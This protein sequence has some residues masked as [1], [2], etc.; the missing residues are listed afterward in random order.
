MNLCDLHDEVLGE[1]LQLLTTKDRFAGVGLVNR[2]LH[3]L[4]LTSPLPTVSLFRIGPFT[5]SPFVK[6]F[7]EYLK[8]LEDE[9]T[10]S[11]AGQRPRDVLSS[12]P[13]S[14]LNLVSTKTLQLPYISLYALKELAN[15]FPNISSCGVAIMKKEEN[16]SDDLEAASLDC[17]LRFPRLQSLELEFNRVMFPLQIPLTLK[18]FKLECWGDHMLTPAQER[19]SPFFRKLHAELPKAPLLEDYS[20][21]SDLTP[22]VFPNLKTLTKQFLRISDIPL[23]NVVELPSIESLSL[24]ADFDIDLSA[25]N[26]NRFAKTLKSLQLINGHS[27]QASHV[28]E[29]KLLDLKLALLTDLEYFSM[30][31]LLSLTSLTANRAYNN[32]RRSK[33]V[34]R[35]MAMVSQL[36]NL[37][38]LSL[39]GNFGALDYST[40]L[41]DILPNLTQFKFSDLPDFREDVDVKLSERFDR[42]R[43]IVKALDPSKLRILRLEY[44]FVDID[45]AAA[46]TEFT[47][48]RH[49]HL[50]VMQPLTVQ[51]MEPFKLMTYLKTLHLW[52]STRELQID[53]DARDAFFRALPNTAVFL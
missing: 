52:E 17:F 46:L 9:R 2:R 43:T 51:F 7:K 35:A 4:S 13:I 22:G 47:A 50:N 37:T 10:M 6:L 38:N 39:S 44:F 49:L 29:L 5:E 41:L 15:I 34:P 3:H 8:A 12:S 33:D 45:V 23:L 21:T 16:K 1:L 11:T 42:T 20:T 31:S 32:S 30:G 27:I 24:N 25:L 26:L 14:Q 18:K 36:T 48:L 53:A 40:I 19:E 28:N